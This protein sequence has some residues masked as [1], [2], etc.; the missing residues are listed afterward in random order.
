MVNMLSRA[1]GVDLNNF[2]QQSDMQLQHQAIAD[3]EPMLMQIGGDEYPEGPQMVSHTSGSNLP[4]YN[5]PTRDYCPLS[6]YYRYHPSLNPQ[7]MN[8]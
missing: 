3:I 7:G 6:V 4:N 5:L 2:F 1:L 8:P